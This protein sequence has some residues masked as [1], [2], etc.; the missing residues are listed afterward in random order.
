MEK[1]A[2]WRLEK[3]KSVQ[4]WVVCI[5]HRGTVGI[6]KEQVL[7]VDV[8]A[9]LVWRGVWCVWNTYRAMDRQYTHGF[10]KKIARQKN[11]PNRETEEHSQLCNHPIY[12]LKN[13]VKKIVLNF[14]EFVIFQI[15]FS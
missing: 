9:C 8:L 5:W 14:L 1:R 7:F 6:V 2:G 15:T 12:D 10:S 11:I 13:L 3:V 4:G